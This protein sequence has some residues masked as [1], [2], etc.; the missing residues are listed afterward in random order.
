LLLKIYG[1]SITCPSPSYKTPEK[2]KKPGDR[3][4]Q[5]YGAV[6]NG[7]EPSKWSEK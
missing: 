4:N 7:F 2:T 1:L 5:D 6:E 3:K